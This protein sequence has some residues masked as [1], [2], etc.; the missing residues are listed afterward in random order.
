MTH[1]EVSLGPLS[2][3]DTE[4]RL[5]SVLFFERSLVEAEQWT[6][7]AH[8]KARAWRAVEMK[9]PPERRCCYLAISGG[10]GKPESLSPIIATIDILECDAII[11]QSL[12]VWRAACLTP[13]GLE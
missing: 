9:T 6:G 2:R 8:E 5:P 12:G 3:P 1:D 11:Q 4:F 7:G 13:Y 10:D